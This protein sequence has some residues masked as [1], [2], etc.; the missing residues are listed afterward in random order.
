MSLP[1]ALEVGALAP[2]LTVVGDVHLNA[3]DPETAERFLAWLAARAGRG[4]TLVLLGDLFEAWAGRP[5]QHESPARET[6]EALRALARGG[7]RVAFLAGN[8]D[9]L[10]DGADGLAL[11]LWPELVRA[12]LGGRPVLLTHGDLLCT[13]DRSYLALRR[14]LRSPL[15]LGAARALPYGLRRR[16]A[17]GLR[18]ISGRAVRAKPMASLGL[19]YAEARRWL[20]VHRAEAL[21][22][23]HVHTGVHHR[24]RADPGLE[25]LVLRDWERGGSVI[26]W[27]GGGLR[28]VAPAS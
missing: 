16:V 14:L 5:Q 7:V 12:H 20:L 13:A 26:E 28:L 23:G 22:A 1:T 11:E 10:F 6:L 21:I 17:G 8:R 15:G 19:D 27:D 9:H 3:G 4:G 24:L 2:P 18:R 25:V